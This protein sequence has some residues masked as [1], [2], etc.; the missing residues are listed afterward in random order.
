MA[1]I[2]MSSGFTLIPEGTYVFQIT[3]VDYD[4][5][6][7][8]LEVKLATSNGMKMVERYSL[9]DANDELNEG[10]LAAF[11]FLAKT[12]LQNFDLP[13]VDPDEL[14]GRYIKADVTHTQ[15]PSKRDPSKTVTFAHLGDKSPADGF[16]GAPAPS[17]APA[18]PAPAAP[19]T[20]T[21]P[22]LAD[23]LG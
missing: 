19:A 12:A 15:A 10:A 4:E 17:S 14:V 1:R 3:D 2:P 5:D 20:K 22:N 21:V 7:G 6:F 16:E 9:K 13:D 23:L 11:S 8:K 18:A